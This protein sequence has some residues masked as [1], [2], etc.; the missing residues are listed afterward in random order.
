MYFATE[1]RRTQVLVWL[2]WA[3]ACLAFWAWPEQA[4]AR[5]L[6]LTV[7]QLVRQVVEHAVDRVAWEVLDKLV[8][9]ETGHALFPTP[10]AWEYMLQR[11][12]GDGRASTLDCEVR[13]PLPIV[14]IGAP[15]AGFIPQVAEKL[16]TL[17]LIP[18]HAEVGNAVGCSHRQRDPHRRDPGATSSHG[19]RHAHV[20]CPRPYRAGEAPPWPKGFLSR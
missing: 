19:G 7:D 10:P 4:V 9:D 1:S 18:S 11:M 8:G 5:Q 13:V 17:C 15:V 14:D 3:V 16:H 20:P 2:V 6:S 12:L